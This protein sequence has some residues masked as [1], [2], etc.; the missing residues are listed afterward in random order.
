MMEYVAICSK[1]LAEE[2]RWKIWDWEA[3]HGL[4]MLF[5][6]M[7]FEDLNKFD[8]TCSLCQRSAKTTRHLLFFCD[9]SQSIWSHILGSNVVTRND[10]SLF[11]WF[12]LR[13][14]YSSK[15]RVKP[16]EAFLF[17]LALADRL[18]AARNEIPG[19][20]L[21]KF[22]QEKGSAFTSMLLLKASYSVAAVV[23]THHNHSLIHLEAM[24]ID[25][26][27]VDVA[28]ANA[29]W[30]AATITLRWLDNACEIGG[31]SMDI[32]N[33]IIRSGAPC[34]RISK[35]ISYIHEFYDKPT[36]TWVHVSID[37]TLVAHKLAAW[38][39]DF[40]FSGILIAEHLPF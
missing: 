30:M 29:A 33:A 13:V 11:E 5:W 3:P 40:G 12:C 21:E 24:R 39:A 23:A 32:I 17:V 35:I 4:K 38:A 9:V 27:D 2:A 34:Q 10:E 31:N 6:R 15:F 16:A 14:L 19:A 36:T 20:N 37:E 18:H 25:S 1:L 28:Q 22:L 8:E 26:T 7:L